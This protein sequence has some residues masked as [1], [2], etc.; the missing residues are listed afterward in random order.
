MDCLCVLNHLRSIQCIVDCS[1]LMLL[2]V[3]TLLQWSFWQAQWEEYY[4]GILPHASGNI[5]VTETNYGIGLWSILTGVSGRKVYDKS[6]F[7]SKSISNVQVKDLFF[8]G[9]VLLSSTLIILSWIRV[10]RH[11]M[12]TTKKGK[13]RL[14]ASA[15]SKF[16]SPLL[17]SLVS[18][19]GF[20]D[21]TYNHG[22][23][24]L[25]LCFCLIT[26]KLI[27][28]SMAKMAYAVIQYDIIPFITVV[29]FMK[30]NTVADVHQLFRLLDLFYLSRLLYWIHK[31]IKQ[32]CKRLKIRLLRIPYDKKS[33]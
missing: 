8:G 23:L 6:L 26:I 19:W 33:N 31:A 14:F 21:S 11:I 12:T 10:Y 16:V 7:S 17:L 2:V 18:L 27:V 3:Q 4:T 30:N 13:I 22:S 1:P 15:M 9:W 29:V 25:G 20:G 28:Y 24:S 5:G 32:L